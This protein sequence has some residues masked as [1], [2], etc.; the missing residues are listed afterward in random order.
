MEGFHPQPLKRA[1]IDQIYA[2]ENTVCKI[3]FKEKYGTGF[4]I[5]LNTNLRG[6]LTCNHLIDN[7][8]L[9]TNISIENLDQT[10]IIKITEDRKVCTNKELDY[11]FIQI[12]ESDGI[13][14]FFEIYPNE[15]INEL[16]GQDIFLLHYPCNEFSFS[17]GV[18]LDVD[19]DIIKHNAPTEYGSGGSPIILRGENNYIIGLHFGCQMNKESVKY[20]LGTL[21]HPILNDIKKL[22]NES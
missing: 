20:N 21:I 12:L 1:E 17:C 19:E 13:Q 4:F 7:I 6:L 15:N 2:K 5:K 3:N 14:N 9:N 8:S 18:I 10:K 11:T 22:M 16:K